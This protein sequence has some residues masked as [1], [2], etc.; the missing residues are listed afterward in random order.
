M[1]VETLTVN[2]S[3]FDFG[4]DSFFVLFVG[5]IVLNRVV[6]V[7]DNSCVSRFVLMAVLAGDDS[8]LSRFAYTAV[9]VVVADDFCVDRFL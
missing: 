1:I 5:V 6:V 3:I 2:I 4:A 8:C 7:G 9:G